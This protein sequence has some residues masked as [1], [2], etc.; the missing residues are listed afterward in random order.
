MKTNNAMI[1][2]ATYPIDKEPFPWK[3]WSGLSCKDTELKYSVRKLR[4]PQERVVGL[5]NLKMV[6]KGGEHKIENITI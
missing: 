6:C 1:G 5:S 3:F 2:N 4:P